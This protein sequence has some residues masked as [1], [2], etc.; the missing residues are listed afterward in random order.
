[1]GANSTSC[2]IQCVVLVAGIIVLVA[3]TKTPDYTLLAL[4]PTGLFL[5]LDI[6]Y[7]ALERA[8]RSSYN[9]FVSKLHRNQVHLEDLFV[10]DPYSHTFWKLLSSHLGSK[11]VWPF[12]VALILTIVF[13]WQLEW[14]RTTLG[15]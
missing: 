11:S 5:Y 14:V 8:F 10:I 9:D 4:V 2:K 6:Y 1:M 3:Q 13:V 7:L 12:Y 15:I